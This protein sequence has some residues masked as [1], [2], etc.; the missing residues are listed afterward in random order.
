MLSSSCPTLAP[1]DAAPREAELSTPGAS[2]GYI[3]NAENIGKSSDEL[4]AMW[5]EAHPDDPVE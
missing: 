2:Q 5:N 4:V 3:I 1:A